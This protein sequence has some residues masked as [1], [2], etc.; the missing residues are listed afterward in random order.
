MTGSVT[1]LS[2]VVSRTRACQPT[3]K[4]SLRTRVAGRCT[5]TVSVSRPHDVVATR[6]AVPTDAGCD[7]VFVPADFGGRRKTGGPVT[8]VRKTAMPLR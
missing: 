8:V 7:A 5:V 4:A 3:E 6:R 1:A 2:V